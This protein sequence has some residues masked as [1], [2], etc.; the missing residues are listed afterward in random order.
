MEESESIEL[1]KSLADPD[2][3][4]S[5][6]VAFANTDGGTVYAGID[7]K[8]GIVGIQMGKKTIENLVGEIRRLT[9]PPLSPRISVEKTG[10]KTVLSIAVEKSASAPHFYRG[11]AYKRIGKT[12]IKMSPSEL[13]ALIVSTSFRGFDELV[14]DASLDDLSLEAFDAFLEVAL[15]KGRIPH[16]PGNLGEAAEKLKLTEKEKLKN[17]ALIAFGKD[18]TRFFPT[19]SVK[20]AYTYGERFSLEKLAEM[21]DFSDPLF[22]AIQK[23][24][25]FILRWLPK[26]YR[27][28]GAVRVEEPVVPVEIIRELVVN[29]LIHRD[30]AA[31]TFVYV[32]I[33]P[34]KLEIKNP[35]ELLPPLKPVDLYKIHS[36][37]LRNPFLA[38]LAFLAGY[39]ENWGQGTWN[40]AKETVK[41]LGRLPEFESAGGFFTVRIRFGPSLTPEEKILAAISR[42]PTRFEELVKKASLSPR[43]MR[44]IL[45]RYQRMGI[46]QK[47]HAGR[48]VLYELAF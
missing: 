46:V 47:H 35:G 13:R 40:V 39:V 22:L 24:T 15:A 20:G 28:K 9:E 34:E 16:R 4:I 6:L 37:R 38:N 11:I 42:N 12:T 30:Y 3:I 29:A 25:E 31:N 2:A 19:Y 26:K 8:G 5:T 14:S 1:K 7:E 43:T 33:T 32:L 17:G 23:I 21:R 27:L 18:P 41:Q 10:D 48:Q 36:S 45:A 44:R